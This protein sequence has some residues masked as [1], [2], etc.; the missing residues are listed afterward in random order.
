MTCFFDMAA[1]DCCFSDVHCLCDLQV[2]HM[3][4]TMPAGLLQGVLLHGPLLG[5]A[6][7]S[8]DVIFQYK[9]TTP[10]GDTLS[11]MMPQRLGLEFWQYPWFSHLRDACLGAK[12]M[13]KMFGEW[14]FVES[15]EE[16]SSIESDFL[17]T[18]LHCFRSILLCVLFVTL[19]RQVWNISRAHCM[20]S[21]WVFGAKHWLE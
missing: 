4:H 18:V 5:W 21:T 3:V 8:G 17:D 10:N 11:Y 20:M 9:Q 6:K 14:T 1:K 15:V 13:L 7:M 16:A 12:N 2:S 19:H